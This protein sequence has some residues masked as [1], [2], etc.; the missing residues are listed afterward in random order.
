[1]KKLL[2]LLM[3][4]AS[5][6]ACAAME[7]KNVPEPWHKPLSHHSLKS[8]Q[9]D[10]GVLRLQLDKPEV[11]EL[12]YSTFIF[13]GICAEQWRTPERYAALGLTRVELLDAAGA[14]GFAFDARGDACEQMG[15]MGKNFRTFIRERTVV[16]Q[17]GTCPRP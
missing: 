11:T 4:A 16:C 7:F 10:N 3:G 1:M 8:A 5:A 13:H 6:L 2:V 9:L 17:G 14:K 12:V 15:Q